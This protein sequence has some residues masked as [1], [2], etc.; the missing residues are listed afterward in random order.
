MNWVITKFKNFTTYIFW[1]QLNLKDGQTNMRN[2]FY[3]S[4][5]NFEINNRKIPLH[6]TLCFLNK[7]INY[8]TIYIYVYMHAV[9]SY[10]ILLQTF[11]QLN[12]SH[13]HTIYIY[14]H[15]QIIFISFSQLKIIYIKGFSLHIYKCKSYICKQI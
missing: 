5:V 8:L 10:Y 14:I 11:C 2:N 15:I 9:Y 13:T 12:L 4:F 7:I 1:K 6:N 3:I